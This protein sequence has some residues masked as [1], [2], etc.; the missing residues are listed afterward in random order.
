MITQL[1]SSGL[2]L[3]YIIILTKKID[4]EI[5]KFILPENNL[6]NCNHK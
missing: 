6:T 4:F 3:K 5:W 1:L 2:Q